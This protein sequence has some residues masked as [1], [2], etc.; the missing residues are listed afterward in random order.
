MCSHSYQLH[1]FCALK[2]SSYGTKLFGHIIC[3][4]IYLFLY[5]NNTQSRERTALS[6][7]SPWRVP[8]RVQRPL[9][10]SQV[11]MNLLNLCNLTFGIIIHCS[12]SPKN[13]CLSFSS[14]VI[15]S[16]NPYSAETGWRASLAWRQPPFPLDNDNY[17]ISKTSIYPAEMTLSPTKAAG[18]KRAF[19]SPILRF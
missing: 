13:A 2:C 7:A 10:F 12:F 3:L 4:F 17:C 15:F 14:P 8:T 11:S 5:I 19:L 6:C 9:Y 16:R 18:K 1:F